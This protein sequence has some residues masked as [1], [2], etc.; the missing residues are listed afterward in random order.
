[1]QKVFSKEQLEAH[2]DFLAE[3]VFQVHTKW[4]HFKQLLFWVRQL[5][6]ETPKG[7]TIVSLERTLLYGGLSLVAPFFQKHNFLSIDCSPP[8]AEERGPYNQPMMNDSRCIRV[9]HTSRASAEVTELTDGVADLVLVPNLVHHISDQQ[10]LFAEMARIL[11]PGGRLFVFEPMLRELHQIPDDYLRYTP[12]GM[13]QVL[14]KAGFVTEKFET[15]GGPFQAISYCWVQALQYFPAQKRSKMEEWFYSQ[16]FPQ[17][18]KW[19]V[20]HQHPLLYKRRRLTLVIHI[21]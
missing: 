18:M 5:A 2:A 1:M 10:Q 21:E 16:H 12:Y 7:K 6:E 11:K 4:P 15:E 19:D 8:S 14:N 9:P 3:K 13:M 20:D 17:L